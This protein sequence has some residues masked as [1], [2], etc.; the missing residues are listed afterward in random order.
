MLV[1]Y[2][3]LFGMGFSTFLLVTGQTIS[4]TDDAGG[5]VW[6]RVIMITVAVIYVVTAF[7]VMEAYKEK[8]IRKLKKRTQVQNS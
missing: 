3:H 7:K 2:S 8:R 4:S 6:M 1:S 5:K